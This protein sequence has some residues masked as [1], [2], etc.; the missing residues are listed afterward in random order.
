MRDV[1]VRRVETLLNMGGGLERILT[2][3]N[4]MS[5]MIVILNEA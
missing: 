1:N 3:G 2:K 5:L 4:P